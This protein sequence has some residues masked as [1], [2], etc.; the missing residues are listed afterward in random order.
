MESLTPLEEAL[1]RALLDSPLLI[2]W[3][4]QNCILEH[5]KIQQLPI[6]LDYHTIASDPSKFWRA[7]H[8]GYLPRHQEMLLRRVRDSAGARINKI[9]AHVSLTAAPPRSP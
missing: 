9:F 6:G 5:P 1:C 7:P 4:A 3:F 8:E 2:R